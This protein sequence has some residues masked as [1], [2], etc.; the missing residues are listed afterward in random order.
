MQLISL[1]ALLPIVSALPTPQDQQPAP[2][3]RAVEIPRAVASAPNSFIISLKPG[4]VDPTGRAEWLTA[5]LA[6]LTADAQEKDNLGGILSS[7]LGG[8]NR[9]SN[10]GR[11]RGQR[12]QGFNRNLNHHDKKSDE[13]TWKL[14]WDEKIFNGFSGSFSDEEIE[15][16]RAQEEVAYIQ[17]GLSVP[18]G[19]LGRAN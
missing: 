16:L 18:F 13:S 7:I 12:Q 5:V 3:K 4:S 9:I 15:L 19:V 10:S 8:L 2:L 14:N 6:S 17:E 1:L 11:N